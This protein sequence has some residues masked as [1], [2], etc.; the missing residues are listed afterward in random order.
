VAT[1]KKI[2]DSMASQ[3]GCDTVR[4]TSESPLLTANLEEYD[5][6]FV[7]TGLFAGSPDE[8]IMRYLSSLTLKTT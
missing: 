3:I 7:G 2:T 8:D 5:L 1:Q 4:I 6:I